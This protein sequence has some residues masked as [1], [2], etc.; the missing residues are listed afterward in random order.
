MKKSELM[1]IVDAVANKNPKQELNFAFIDFDN[2][3]II[4]TDTYKLVKYHLREDEVK[5]C[6]GKHFLH[7]KILKAIIGMFGKIDNAYF[8]DNKIILGNI[9]VGI[10]NIHNQECKYPTLDDVLHKT[11]YEDSY[12]VDNLHFI[13]FD[14]THKNTHINSDAFKILQEHAHAG[15]YK[16]DSIPQTKDAVGRARIIGISE[17]KQ[18]FTCIL[19]GVEYRPQAPTLFDY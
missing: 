10:N 9:K 13:D 19:T 6:Y 7:K 3:F 8:E 5:D 18:R 4:A 1:I 15:K 11:M 17:N 14:L 16:V 2:M 12:T